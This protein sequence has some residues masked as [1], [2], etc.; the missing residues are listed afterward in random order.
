MNKEP[1]MS[2]EENER[3]TAGEL[4]AVHAAMSRRSGL[5]AEDFLTGDRV[6]LLPRAQMDAGG[7]SG[8]VVGFEPLGGVLV[9]LHQLPPVAAP[10]AVS[11][12]LLERDFRP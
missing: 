6:R 11:P 5:R 4:Q 12:D 1:Y 7:H 8:T 2:Q 3:A 10:V 9:A